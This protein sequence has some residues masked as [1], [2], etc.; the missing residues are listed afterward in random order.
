[1]YFLRTCFFF[2]R[3]F[4]SLSFSYT[5]WLP[6][7]WFCCPRFQTC[8]VHPPK[9]KIKTTHSSL[10]SRLTC[11]RTFFLSGH[12]FFFLSLSRPFVDF[13][14]LQGTVNI[15]HFSFFIFI[16]IVII[17]L[18]LL[19]VLLSLLVVHLFFCFFS[20]FLFCFCFRQLSCV[21]NSLLYMYVRISYVYSKCKRFFIIHGCAMG[22]ASNY[23]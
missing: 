11:Y 14:F 18:F 15:N 5:N 8:S 16:S 6:S 3:F 23:M 7:F 20:L 21:R 1:M 10:L 4:S 22:N 2:P 12:F 13:P 9:T 17:F 19:L